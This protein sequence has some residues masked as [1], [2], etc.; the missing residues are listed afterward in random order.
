MVQ[1]MSGYSTF[2]WSSGSLE[3]QCTHPVDTQHSQKPPNMSRTKCVFRKPPPIS[4]FQGESN[5]RV[6]HG[7]LIV[8]GYNEMYID[9]YVMHTTV[10]GFRDFHHSQKPY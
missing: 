9:N 3:N 4:K 5:H 2:S 8:S 10:I 1:V 6:Q 7:C